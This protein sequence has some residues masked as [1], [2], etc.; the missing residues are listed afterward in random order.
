MSQLEL[1]SVIPDL[2]EVS[3]KRLSELGDSALAHSIATYRERI[4]DNGLPLS[5]FNSKI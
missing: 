3:L 4:K 5:S 2:R 1:R